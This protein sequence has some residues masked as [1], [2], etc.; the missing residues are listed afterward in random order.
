MKLNCFFLPVIAILALIYGGSVA[1][2]ATSDPAVGPSKA[3]AEKVVK[4][5]AAAVKKSI[6]NSKPDYSHVNP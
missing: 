5:D 2:R 1:Y 6:K 4:G 3:A